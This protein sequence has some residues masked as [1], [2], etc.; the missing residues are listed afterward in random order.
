MLTALYIRMRNM[1]EGDEGATAL[2][3]GILVAFIAIVIIV[4]V[5]AFGGALN[6]FF[7]GLWG[8]T[9]I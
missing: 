5:T 9:G 3:Y 2:E 8:R 4:G 1:I 6:T 7:D